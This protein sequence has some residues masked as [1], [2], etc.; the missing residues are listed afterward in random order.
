MRKSE[1]CASNDFE[2]GAVLFGQIADFLS[3]IWIPPAN[4]P[5]PDSVASRTQF[6]CGSCGVADTA[7]DLA[8]RTRGAVEFIG[9]W[10]THPGSHPEPSSTDRQAI[11][12]LMGTS[13]FGGRQFLMLIVGGYARSPFVAGSLFKR[14]E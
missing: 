12:K 4:G 3:I 14:D 1:R 2:T 7:Q 5:P 6:I 9:M 10:H 13:D 8:E 11:R